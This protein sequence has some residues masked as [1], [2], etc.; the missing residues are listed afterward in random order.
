MTTP[1][2]PVTPAAVDVLE[3]VAPAAPRMKRR[4]L[5]EVSALLRRQKLDANDTIAIGLGTQYLTEKRSGETSLP[6]R[7]WLDEDI[8]ENDDDEAGEEDDPTE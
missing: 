6:F 1:K 7:E 5:L 8:P 2:K 4:D 3:D